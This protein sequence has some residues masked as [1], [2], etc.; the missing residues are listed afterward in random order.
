MSTLITNQELDLLVPLINFFNSEALW[1]FF[2]HFGD[3]KLL[4]CVQT[5]RFSD[6]SQIFSARC[7]CVCV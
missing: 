3:L 1:G 4:A 7:V 6:R 2:P 5:A